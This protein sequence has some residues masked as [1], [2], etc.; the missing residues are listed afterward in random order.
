MSFIEL[1][2]R[3]RATALVD[4]GTARELVGPFD[5]VESPWL[6]LQGVTPQADDGCVVIK[7]KIGGIPAVAIALEIES[8]P[9]TLALIPY[10]SIL[11]HYGLA[12]KAYVP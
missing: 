4:P 6:P 7:G 1:H 11:P 2:A 9:P 5:R 12:S 3:E 8:V 10:S